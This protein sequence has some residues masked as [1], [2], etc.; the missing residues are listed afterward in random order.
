KG[1]V[2]P[3][4]GL[5]EGLDLHVPAA[6]RL[7]GG[8]GSIEIGSAVRGVPDRR[9]LQRRAHLDE[10]SQRDPPKAQEL[11]ESL[12]RGASRHRL[13]AGHA[14]RRSGAARNDETLSLKGPERLAHRR[15]A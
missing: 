1:K 15:A 12:A 7:K 14:K 11:T 8:P 2:K 6:H 3:D 4:I 13:G 5:L 10:I 9:R